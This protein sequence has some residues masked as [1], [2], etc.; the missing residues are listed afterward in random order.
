[1]PHPAILYPAGRHPPRC[2]CRRRCQTRNVDSTRDD[3]VTQPC[4]SGDEEEE[5][6]AGVSAP[7][8]QLST[9]ES[10]PLLPLDAD[11]T[12][13][14]LLAVC[15][16]FQ[17]PKET[18]AR[19]AKRTMMMM[20]MTWFRC[21]MVA[22]GPRGRGLCL[23]RRE[24]GAGALMCLGRG[25]SGRVVPSREG[26]PFDWNVPRRDERWVDRDGVATQRDEAARLSL[27]DDRRRKTWEECGM[28]RGG[29]ACRS[30][31]DILVAPPPTLRPQKK[32]PGRREAGVNKNGK[33]GLSWGSIGALAPPA[34]P[35]PKPA[36]SG[37]RQGQR[38]PDSTGTAPERLQLPA[39][40]PSGA[41][42]PSWRW[43][44]TW[45][46]P[47]GSRATRALLPN[48][49]HLGVVIG[50][51]VNPLL[52]TASGNT[53]STTSWHI[54]VRIRQSA[55]RLHLRV[56]ASSQ[57]PKIVHSHPPLLTAAAYYKASQKESFL[58]SH[59]SRFIRGY[60]K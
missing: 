8:G 19:M 29:A 27:G 57:Q 28:Q 52:T 37:R 32:G 26:K 39:R 10:E 55:D 21:T 16:S 49:A 2:R 35:R 24:T 31:A 50:P 60:V 7:R 41:H 6:D 47:G 56:P 59:A 22:A 5:G 46:V 9:R 34:R 45:G 44:G 18:S 40:L 14:S 36:S 33:A 30:G 11:V 48:L 43:Q 53:A 15:T 3:E 51:C 23:E 12:L 25:P 17:M 42:L 58:L 1:M 13:R 54:R 4:G 20:A 38:A